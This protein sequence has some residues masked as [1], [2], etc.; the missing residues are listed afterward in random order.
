[1]KNRT[2]KVSRSVKDKQ[3]KIYECS[4]SLLTRQQRSRKTLSNTGQRQSYTVCIY[5]RTVKTHTM[6]I[7]AIIFQG[8]LGE[9]IKESDDG[10]LQQ[11][12][13]YGHCPSSQ[14]L[15]PLYP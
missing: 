9:N 12:W 3:K 15:Q 13:Y 7:W 5:M 1:M 8:K 10:K 2:L 14:I 4:L 11:A 6:C